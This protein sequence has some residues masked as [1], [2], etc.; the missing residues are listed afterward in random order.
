MKKVSTIFGTFLALFIISCDGEDGRDGVDGLDGVNVVGNI[1]EIE[2]DFTPDN[3]YS[4]LFNFPDTVEVFESD[5]VL[6]Y[7]LWEQTENSAGEAV[8][9]WRLLPQ[10]RLLDQGILQYNYDHTYLDAR[11]FLESDFDLG[12][13][14]SGDTDNQVFRI[15]IMPADYAEA[16]MDRS[17]IASVMQTMGVSENEVQK[18]ALD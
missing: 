11:I 12:T 14:P 1:Y 9:V 13:L 6:V 2:D 5:V 4:L 3:D 16:K 8:D 10:T 15:A 17:N 7:I 18:I